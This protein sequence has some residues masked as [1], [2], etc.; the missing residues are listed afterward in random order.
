MKTCSGG[1]GEDEGIED[2]VVVVP[3]PAKPRNLSSWKEEEGSDAD[4][5]AAETS[6]K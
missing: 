5:G 1:R 2:E 4:R 3:E 6:V